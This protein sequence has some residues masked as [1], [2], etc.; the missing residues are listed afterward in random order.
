MRAR[1]LICFSG[2]NKTTLRKR[3]LRAELH[4]HNVASGVD[5]PGRPTQACPLH[6]DSCQKLLGS[7][8][9]SKAT[10]EGGIL[11]AVRQSSLI[12]LHKGDKSSYITHQSKANGLPLPTTVLIFSD[13]SKNGNQTTSSNGPN[14]V[15]KF[16]FDAAESGAAQNKKAGRPYVGQV[17]IMSLS[18]SLCHRSPAPTP[19]NCPSKLENH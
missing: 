18:L 2:I 19:R 3:L 14:S 9:A 15:A 13:R 17:C 7:V 5:A 11:V 16:E 12:F 4:V 8:V 6:F 1:K 10:E